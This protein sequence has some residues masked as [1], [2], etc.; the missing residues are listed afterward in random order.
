MRMSYEDSHRHCITHYA[1]ISISLIDR[2]LPSRILKND[3]P[4]TSLRTATV[5][6]LRVLGEFKV[7]TD[8]L[9]TGYRYDV[10]LRALRK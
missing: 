2:I 9:E 7:E 3:V 4:V 8:P 10:E 5:R 1:M 6:R